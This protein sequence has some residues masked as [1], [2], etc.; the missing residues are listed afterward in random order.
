M[1]FRLEIPKKFGLKI[2]APRGVGHS[3]KE[4]G[5]ET[6]LPVGSKTVFQPRTEDKPISVA[7]PFVTEEA[8]NIQFSVI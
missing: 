5:R 1:S 8:F 3:R 7:Q 6:N 2:S 4:G